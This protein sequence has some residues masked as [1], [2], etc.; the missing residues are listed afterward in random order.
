MASNPY[1]DLLKTIQATE[2]AKTVGEH[3]VAD[4]NRYFQV[5]KEVYVPSQ[6]IKP[7]SLGGCFREQYFILRGAERD[8]GK[9]EPAENITIQC[10]GNDAHNRLQNAC[11]DAKRFGIDIIWCDPEEEANRASRCGINTTIKRRDGNELLCHNSDYN[12]NFKCDGII[13]YKDI[14]YILEIKTEEYY[15]FNCRISP[16]PKHVF[17]AGL[18]CLCFGIDRVMFLYEDRNLTFRKGFEIEIKEDY[19]EVLKSRIQHIL[20]Y[21]SLEKV[22]PKE[23]DKCTYCSYKQS[24]KKTG[25]TREYSLEDLKELIERG[26]SEEN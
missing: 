5:S 22:P 10:S 9:L 26:K 15:K 16:E 21:N 19:K 6:T 20:G 8:V 25:D 14:K 4:I 17:Q 1:R 3:F 11:Q 13:I 12:T 23:K 18:Y 2:K 7:S 24:C